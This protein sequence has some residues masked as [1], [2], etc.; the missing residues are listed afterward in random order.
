MDIIGLVFGVLVYL[1]QQRDDLQD[2][3]P[4]ASCKT[5]VVRDEHTKLSGSERDMM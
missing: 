3:F 4:L 2:A 1:F 5:H